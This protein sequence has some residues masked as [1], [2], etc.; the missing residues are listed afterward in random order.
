MVTPGSDIPWQP[1]GE[2]R[3]RDGLRFSALDPLPG[4]YRVAVGAE[5]YIGE[6]DNLARAMQRF[7]TPG[8]SQPTNQRV[9][10]W[11]HRVLVGG[12]AGQVSV[13]QRGAARSTDG[14][15]DLNNA[16]DRRALKAEAVERERQAN[17]KLI[18]LQW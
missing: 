5:V 2:V 6:A 3:L 15:V 1:V 11:L 10:D 17:K 13:V 8:S 9:H 16:E 12:V 18:N 7:R 4:V 14:H